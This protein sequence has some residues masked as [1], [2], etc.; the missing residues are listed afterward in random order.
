MEYETLLF[1]EEWRVAVITLI[2]PI[3]NRHDIARLLAELSELL[4]LLFAQNRL[5]NLLDGLLRL[6]ELALF[7][8][9]NRFF[10]LVGSV[11]GR[12]RR[13]QAGHHGQRDTG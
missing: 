4:L 2:K 3:E 11:L 6:L 10:E 1:S 8:Q 7:K 13:A 12:G 9:F 5:V